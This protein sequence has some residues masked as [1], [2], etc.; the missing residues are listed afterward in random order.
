M[1]QDES[2]TKT[3][4]N[5][6]NRSL[7]LF[8]EL[9]AKELNEAGLDMKKVL[10][11]NVDIPWNKTTVKEYIWRPIQKALTTKESTTDIDT[12]EPSEIWEIINRHLGEKFGIEVPRFPSEEQTKEYLESYGK[13]I[14]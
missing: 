1:T 5:P 12:K 7:H 9:L 14:N 2:K 10:K 6:Q 8:C 4:T 3:R 13:D 11:P